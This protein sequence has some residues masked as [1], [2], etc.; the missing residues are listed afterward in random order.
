[1]KILA[2]DYGDARTGLAICDESELLATPLPQLNEKSMNKVVALIAQA[3]A[4]QKANEVLN[5][6]LTKNPDEDGFAVMAQVYSQD[7]GSASNGGLYEDV[8]MGQ[9]VEPFENWCFDAA[10]KTGDYGIVKTNYGYHIMYYVG[11]DYVW[12]LTAESDMMVEKG[13]EFL[14]SI[15]EK[16]PTVIDYSVIELGEVNLAAEG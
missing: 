15:L 10:R 9:M 1:M 8:Y 6:W 3:A 4:E 11:G 16:H 7:P 14:Q 5:E 12:Y 2:V 13:N